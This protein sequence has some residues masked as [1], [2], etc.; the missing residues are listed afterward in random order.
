[1]FFITNPKF[2][3]F[4]QLALIFVYD[5][6]PC[7]TTLFQEHFS[8]EAQQT[9]GNISEKVIWSYITQIT[10][11]LKAI[12]SSGLAARVIEP[13]KILLTGKNR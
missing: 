12:H 4:D 8:T 13:T 10:S 1:M 5:Y 3:N 11:A 6:H 7:S 2:S 9:G